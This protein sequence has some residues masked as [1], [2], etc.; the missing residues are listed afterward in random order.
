MYDYFIKNY[1][2]NV[3]MVFTEEEKRAIY[4][5]TSIET[6]KVAIEEQYYDIQPGNIADK[7]E[8]IGTTDY[9]N[10]NDISNN[11]ADP[12]FEG[13]NSVKLYRLNGSSAKTGLSITLKI[14]HTRGAILG[15][16]DYYPFGLTMAGISSKALQFGQPENRK[17]YNGIEF[18]N[19]LDLNLYDAQFRDLD[20]Q[21]SWQMVAD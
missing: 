14:I 13:T 18:E 21:V 1:L 20:T 9:Q 11:P 4:L 8:A 5:L 3:R 16:T 19:D 10:N 6:S 12:S 15:E 17:K 7:S 2:D